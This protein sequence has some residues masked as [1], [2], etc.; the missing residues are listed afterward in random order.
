MVRKMGPGNQNG[1][2][3]QGDSVVG[4]S[5]VGTTMTDDQGFSAALD[6]WCPEDKKQD[7]LKGFRCRNRMHQ[8][9][10][11]FLPCCNWCRI[12]FEPSWAAWPVPVPSRIR[13]GICP[14]IPVPHVR[15]YMYLLQP[16]NELQGFYPGALF[17]AIKSGN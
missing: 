5:G 4:S 1:A 15:K 6:L 8:T 10:I 16:A 2:R 11:T 12:C 13:K 3:W 14:V 9:S 17:L 7:E